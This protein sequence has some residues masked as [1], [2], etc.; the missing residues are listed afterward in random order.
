MLSSVINEEYDGSD[1]EEKYTYI[2][3]WPERLY[4][5]SIYSPKPF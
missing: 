2:T 3:L 5:F 4:N 1:I